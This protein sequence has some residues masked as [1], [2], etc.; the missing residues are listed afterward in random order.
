MA[1]LKDLKD[2]SPETPSPSPGQTTPSHSPD[3]TTHKSGRTNYRWVVIGLG[4]IITLINYMDRSAISYAIAPLQ[5]EF[6][7]DNEAFG[8]IAAAFGIGY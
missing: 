8:R 3:Q 7:I 2:Y 4:F 1:D 5:H 6:G